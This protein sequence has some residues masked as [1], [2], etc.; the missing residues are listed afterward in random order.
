MR[1][2]NIYY[3]KNIFSKYLFELAILATPIYVSDHASDQRQ[4]HR[5]I[6]LFIVNFSS[7]LIGVNYGT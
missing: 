7:T 1:K 4:A 2:L 6:V 3:T 5:E